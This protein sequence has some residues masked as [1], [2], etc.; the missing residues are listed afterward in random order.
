VFVIGAGRNLGNKTF[1]P[2]APAGTDEPALPAGFIAQFY[3]DKQISPQL[4]CSA[5]SS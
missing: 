1:F 2:Q 3:A 5:L 4:V